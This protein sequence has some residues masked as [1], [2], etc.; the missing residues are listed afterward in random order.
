MAVFF[1]GSSP[2]MVVKLVPSKDSESYLVWNFSHCG[3]TLAEKVEGRFQTKCDPT[4]K[5]LISGTGRL[6]LRM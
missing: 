1:P 5:D 4:N 2:A 6:H 3:A